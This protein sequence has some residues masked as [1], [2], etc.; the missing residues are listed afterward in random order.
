MN[1]LEPIVF[2]Q[3]GKA[4]T[5]SRMVANKFGKRHDNVVRAIR[6][7]LNDDQDA[8]LNFEDGLY[9]DAQGQLRPYFTMDETGFTLLVFGFNN[10]KTAAAWKRKY[11]HA[12][13]AMRAELSNMAI[14][15]ANKRTAA[16]EAQVAQHQRLLEA[17]GRDYDE[18]SKFIQLPELVKLINVHPMP[19]RMHG[20]IVRRWTAFLNSNERSSVPI[21]LPDIPFGGSATATI[22][23]ANA[24]HDK[25]KAVVHIA[26]SPE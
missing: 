20:G 18:D 26:A 9:L 4:M 24:L 7:I 12:F 1:E 16:L 22:P 8:H 21:D 3:D 10:S 17:I 25:H 19:K 6:N 13:Q 2:E 15:E 11:V 23:A 5:D 14:L